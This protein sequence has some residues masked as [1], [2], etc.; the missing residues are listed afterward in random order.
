MWK[1]K[2]DNSKAIITAERHVISSHKCENRVVLPPKAV[3]F[4][5]GSAMDYLKSNYKMKI[6]MKK[7]PKFLGG[8]ECLIIKDYPNICFVHGG[9]GSPAIADTVETLI[10]L[11]VK[12]IILI[13]MCGGFSDKVNVGDIIIPNKVLSEEGTSLHY[14]DNIQF[15]N[16][17][18]TLVS[19]GLSYFSQY[20]STYKLNTVT[21]DAIYRQTFYKEDYWR[22]MDCVGVD[23]EASALLSV[24]KYHGMEPIV[25]LLVSDKHPINNQDEGWHWGSSNFDCIKDKFISHSIKYAIDDV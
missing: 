13:G 3:I 18:E 25:I 17:S 24:S 5:V 12:D 1:H 21:T 4:C 15:I 10:A 23:M 20:F 19:K 22:K 2:D 16:Q 14:Y 7:I 11:G 6:I 8:S 9:Y